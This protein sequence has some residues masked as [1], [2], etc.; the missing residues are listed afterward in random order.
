L[1]PSWPHWRRWPAATTSRCPVRWPPSAARWLRSKACWTS[2]FLMWIWSKSFP[3]ISPRRNRWRTPPKTR[4]SRWALRDIRLCMPRSAPWPNSRP[5]PVC[6]PVVSC[7]STWNWSAPKS[8][9]S[10]FRIWWIV[11]RWPW[12]WSVCSLARRL[13]TTPAWSRLSSA[14]RSSASW[15]TSWPSPSAYG[16]SSTST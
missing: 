1:P 8:R 13:S 4:S 10:C 9:S 11:W 16:S 2:S 3:T 12:L 6:W 15:A 7:A 14:F 5:W